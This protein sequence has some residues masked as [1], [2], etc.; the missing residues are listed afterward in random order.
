[1]STKKTSKYD[2]IIEKELKL[3]EKHPLL[4]SAQ[5]KI[6]NTNL[7]YIRLLK[8][9][10]SCSNSFFNEKLVVD[11]IDND[12][13]YL[14]LINEIQSVGLH[15]T[16]LY[17]QIVHDINKKNKLQDSDCDDLKEQIELN[18]QN[19]YDINKKYNIIEKLT[20]DQVKEAKDS[21]NKLST[22][23]DRT[24]ENNINFLV[25]HYMKD[26]C[27]NSKIK[28]DEINKKFNQLDKQKN[29]ELK[30]I[31]KS[32]SLLKKKLIVLINHIINN[33]LKKIFIK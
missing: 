4:V 26:F 5:K 33:Y 13:K 28:E 30:E 21:V 31:R 7:D 24:L 19:I 2:K 27:T 10:L 22:K 1:M 16:E 14:S 9:I 18:K 12:K 25:E 29:N 6:G 23:L 15:N 11:K 8:I 3:I 20:I 32:I 17:Q